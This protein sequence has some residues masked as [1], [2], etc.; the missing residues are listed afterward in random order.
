MGEALA[1]IP[2]RFEQACP[3]GALILPGDQIHALGSAGRPVWVHAAC[4]R[5]AYAAG[6]AQAPPRPGTLPCGHRAVYQR[7]P[8]RGLCRACS[9][10]GILED[11]APLEPAAPT[12][13]K[14]NGSGARCET[15]DRRIILGRDGAPMP[16]TTPD[17]WRH[18]A[19]PPN[20]RNKATA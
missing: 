5:I 10:A 3:C 14:V 18:A 13:R 11:P 16:G 1:T 20:R 8:R 15:C 6:A 19:C 12:H 7:G 17:T 2:A 4:A 9:R